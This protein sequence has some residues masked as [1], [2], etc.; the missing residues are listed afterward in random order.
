MTKDLSMIAAPCGRFE[1][2]ALPIA[3]HTPGKAET[4]GADDAKRLV[5]VAME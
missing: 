1:A 5:M 2:M 4:S 3:G